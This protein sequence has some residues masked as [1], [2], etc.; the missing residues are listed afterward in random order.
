MTSMARRVLFLSAALAAGAWSSIGSG[1]GGGDD[2]EFDSVLRE[3]GGVGLM[4]CGIA[5]VGETRE[6]DS[7]AVRAH[8]ADHTF[9]AIYEQDD[10]GLRAIVHA[11]GDTYHEVTLSPDGSIVR[12]QCAAAVLVQESGRSYIDCDDPEEPR[13]VC[14]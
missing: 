14:E 8:Q 3:V 6:V 12:A 4:D 9:R 1:C 2:C 5:D 11:A 13:T 7:C 10:G